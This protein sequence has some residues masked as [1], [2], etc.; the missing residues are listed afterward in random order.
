MAKQ[1]IDH[2][3]RLSICITLLLM[4]VLAPAQLGLGNGKQQ[5]N[6]GSSEATALT[7]FIESAGQALAQAVGA[8]ERRQR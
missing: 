6:P 7:D 3:L 4:P 1:Q 8:D 5:N 2:M